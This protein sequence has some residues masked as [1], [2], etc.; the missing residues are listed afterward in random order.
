MVDS[1]EAL[2]LRARDAHARRDFAAA[3]A[4]AEAATVQ[5]PAYLP[6]WL[7]LVNSYT[8][9]SDWPAALAAVR[10]A[11]MQ[12]PADVSLALSAALIRG[13]MQ[14]LEGALDEWD[15]ILALAPDNAMALAMRGALAL[16]LQRPRAAEADVTRALRL[17]PD[18]LVALQ[19]RTSLHLR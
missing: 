14:D 7:G 9:V 3:Q 8:A 2:T 19:T 18:N 1:A 4:A 16:Q 11:Q 10:R 17:D 5:D 6:G 15:H 12:Y 13:E